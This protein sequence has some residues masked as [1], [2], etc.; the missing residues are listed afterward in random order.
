MG[1][2]D[3][4]GGPVPAKIED[5]IP[6]WND[7]TTWNLAALTPIT[8]RYTFRA[9]LFRYAFDENNFASWVQDDWAVTDRLTLNLGLRY[10][11]AMG[12]W[13]NWVDLPPWLEAGR[14]NDTNNFQPR[15]GFA[16]TLD[17]RTVLRGGYG[18]YYGEII[19][20]MVSHTQR[21]TKVAI[22]S[23]LP[24]GRPDFAANPFNGP[25]PGY[26]EL[27]QRFCSHAQV[28]GCVRQDTGGDN[29]AP[30]PAYARLPYS[31][32][33]SIG[34]ERQL[35]TALAVEADY[36]FTGGRDE[37][38]VQ[39]NVNLTFDPATG[40]NY[41][42][43]DITRR[44]FPDWGV[45][46]MNVMGGRSNYHGLQTAFT[47]R[48]NQRWQASGTYTL[49]AVRDLNPMPMSGITRV[50]FPVAPDLGGEYTLAITDQRHRAGVNG[51]WQVGYGF[52]LSGVYF[53]GSGARF[54]TT[55]GG[56]RRNTGASTGGGGRLRPD[57][58]IMPR[59]NLVG[60]PIH[61][62]DLRVQRR[63]QFGSRVRLD[64]MIEVY[65]VFNHENFGSYTTAE[66][67][68]NFGL[69]QPNL[70]I[71]YQPRMVQLGFRATF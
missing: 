25:W 35:A 55:Y 19:T 61:R 8:R 62:V 50:T 2:I 22:A 14:P 30:P 37:R 17:N 59:N 68:A 43:N 38:Y 60:D 41:P 31:H 48:M 39:N 64:G 36:V 69:P 23:V 20:N 7:V 28:P 45:V 18:R 24:D 34:V 53:Y 70:N 1:L 4:Q 44:A 46:G 5:L 6:V 29:L 66:S 56:D 27:V 32:Q 58:T 63:F 42:F 57:G 54:N 12:V 65:N 49:S 40:V 33:V 26:E 3:A 15:L 67:N 13:A 21:Q 47:K 10:D 11:V 71:V 52:Q 16:F 51:I 9:G